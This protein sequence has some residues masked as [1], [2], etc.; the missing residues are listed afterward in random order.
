M[1]KA[2]QLLLFTPFLLTSTTGL[3]AQHS[4]VATMD[5]LILDNSDTFW[6]GAD[7]KGSFNASGYIFPNSHNQ[8]WGSWSGWSYSNRADTTTSGYSNQYSC[9][10]GG[11]LNGTSN[12][13]VSSGSPWIILP[14]KMTVTGAY[15]C[16][17][18]YAALSMRDGDAFAK[19]F[20]GD[21]G[22]EK[23]WFL[24]KAY[25]YKNGSIQDSVQIYLA[26]YRFANNDDDY[27]IN[28]WTWLD[29]RNLGDVDSINFGLS[30]TDNGQ[31]G[32]NTPAY[33][34]LDDFNGLA[35][36]DTVKSTTFN[37]WTLPSDS[38]Y[39]GSDDAGGF[40]VEGSFFPNSYSQSWKSW[41]GWSISNTSDT[42]D[43]TFVNQYSAKSNGNDG[44][45]LVSFGNNSV[46]FGLGTDK[47]DI[48]V[49]DIGYTIRVTNSTYVY[50]TLKDGGQ[51]S[52]KFGGVSGNDKDYL[53][54]NI[55]SYDAKNLAMDTVQF[56]L[57]DYRFDDNSKD[58]IIGDWKLISIDHIM[59]DKDVVRLDFIL[60]SSDTGQFGI[61]TPLYFCMDDFLKL[62]T[63]GV[64]KVQLKSVAV[65]PN[66]TTDFVE[67]EGVNPDKARAI[68][69]N[70]SIAELPI[71]NGRV[72]LRSLPG[73]LYLIE[74]IEQDKLYRNKVFKQ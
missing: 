38:F 58:Y 30:S 18:T 53:R 3:N 73:G 51:F 32:M 48:N 74:V 43:G 23:D 11:A 66:P 9:F 12:F 24:L 13:A 69:V 70:G 50:K 36:N 64:A 42:T 14:R 55:V 47:F 10:A 44:N 4:P 33:F 60:E 1:R 35:P 45:Y 20:G 71:S 57:A 72:D 2:F 67:F 65:Y 41:T 63:T 31:F 62:G 28:K 8:Q 49:V 54:L 56:Y 59:R 16:N 27:I 5:N 46:R 29:M 61:N 52:K 21:K 39:N 17:A 7:L 19:K 34:C 68:S 22:D 26:D 37:D 25:G 15:V 40:T 6:N